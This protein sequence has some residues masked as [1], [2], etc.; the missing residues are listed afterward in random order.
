MR[1]V[2]DILRQSP[3]DLEPEPADFAGEQGARHWIPSRYNI[4]AI[5]RDGRLVLW[6]TLHGSLSVFKA[7]QAPR[8]LE[9]LPRKGIQAPLE[10][11][12]QYLVERGFL[13]RNGANEFRQLQ[14]LH[15]QQHYRSDCLH[16][17]LLASED[18]NFRCRYCYEKYERGTM[19]PR[20]RQGL[21]RLIEKRLPGLR[22]LRADWFGGEPLYGWKAIEELGPFFIE[23]AEKHG[24]S[25]SS[26]MTTNGY[27]LTPEVAGKLLAWKTQRFQITLDGPPE[28]HDQSRPTRNGQGTF[29]TI[30]ENLKSLARRQEDFAVLLRVNFDQSNHAQLDR[31]FERFRRE[32]GADSRF[33]FDFHPVGRWGGARDSELAVCGADSADIAARLRAAAHERGLHAE[34]MGGSL[35]PGSRVCYAARP[36]SF[37]IGAS[38]KVM[39]CTLSLDSDERNV[40]GHLTPDG[41]LVLDADKMGLWTEPAFEADPRCRQC[42]LLP[43]CQGMSCPRSR[44]QNQESPCLPERWHPKRRML[45]RL[46]TQS[47]MGRHTRVPIPMGG[48][49]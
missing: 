10:G 40:V 21:K 25:F 44:I 15:G 22:E 20:V 27:L 4:R 5:A 6:N 36:Y 38:G 3:H 41:E 37:V 46:N 17:I 49:D 8:V 47:G 26:E 48:I 24:V 42:V 11:L 18:C 33:Q 13:I 9:L 2:E 14:L 1:G 23:A 19:Y 7:E 45:E 34:T 28:C 16:L 32:V 30:L 35:S 12:V 31:L 29:Q 39:K 43:G